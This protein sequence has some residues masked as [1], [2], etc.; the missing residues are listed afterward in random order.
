MSVADALGITIN[1]KENSLHSGVLF[2]ASLDRYMYIEIL[3]GDP[4]TYT[5]T[6]ILYYL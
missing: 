2:Y 6:M 5:C 3:K 1:I 4:L